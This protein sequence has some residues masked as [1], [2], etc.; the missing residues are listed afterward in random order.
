M[1]LTWRRLLDSSFA[2]V[3][4][5]FDG[6]DENQLKERDSRFYGIGL[7]DIQGVKCRAGA[8]QEAIE[9]IAK[10]VLTPALPRPLEDI[11]ALRKVAQL[12]DKAGVPQIEAAV[13]RLHAADLDWDP[14]LSKALQLAGVLM[15]RPLRE[16]ADCLSVVSVPLEDA[17]RWDLLSL[18]TPRW[19]NGRAAEPV[20]RFG[21]AA[22]A[23][24]VL[25]LNARKP[26]T[27]GDYVARA[28]SHD[29]RPPWPVISVNGVSAS[30]DGSDLATHALRAIAIK[31]A[32]SEFADRPWDEECD[33]DARALLSRRASDR[34]PVYVVLKQEKGVNL[35]AARQLQ[36]IVGITVIYL[37]EGPETP[38]PGL[39]PLEPR[40]LAEQEMDAY[41][42]YLQAL[43]MT[44]REGAR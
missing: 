37:G 40:L 42:D 4:V 12:L 11:A 38:D 24:P 20:W 7:E 18:L 1:V 43:S 13:E 39:V 3:P 2:V 33:N 22:G 25:I 41:T 36:T 8:E 29:M 21:E 10:A 30:L 31:M 15:Q 5:F 9:A 23:K 19:V 28:W 16:L 6:V 17:D 35:D 14:N 44:Q 32:P 26:K 34:Q 27:A